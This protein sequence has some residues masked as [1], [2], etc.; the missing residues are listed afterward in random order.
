MSVQANV[1]S[2]FMTEEFNLTELKIHMH[3]P[4]KGASNAITV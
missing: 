3:Q 4:T 1:H 2:V